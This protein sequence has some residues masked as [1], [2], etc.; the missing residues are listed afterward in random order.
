[1]HRT[2]RRDRD[3]A[4][5]Q[6]RSG[7]ADRAAASRAP[8]LCVPCLVDHASIEIAGSV[9][10]FRARRL[11]SIYGHCNLRLK[12]AETAD[13]MG[14]RRA[15]NAD[16]VN[17]RSSSRGLGSFDSP[18]PAVDS[19]VRRVLETAKGCVCA[20]NDSSSGFTISSAEDR[21]GARRTH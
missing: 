8:L 21:D 9:Q 1:M 3:R 16:V 14:L 12:K 10:S 17:D 2:V 20:S 15:H 19:R 7:R 11:G 18:H 13:E 6:G 4:S 5:I